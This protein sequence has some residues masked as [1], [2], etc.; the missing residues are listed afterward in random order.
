MQ[1]CN[2]DGIP[3]MARGLQICHCEEAIGRRGNLGKALPDPYRPP[4]KRCWPP[5]LSLRGGRRPTWQSRSSRSDRRKAIG[6]IATASPRF[7][8]RFAP[9]N[10]KPESFSLSTFH[11]RFSIP[12]MP[13]PYK[14]HTLKFSAQNAPKL[15]IKISRRRPGG[16]FWNLQISLRAYK[17]EWPAGWRSCCSCNNGNAADCLQH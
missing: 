11:F 12:R 13:L 14:R 1:V 9:R 5:Y 17:A 2:K 3:S 10:D 7:P 8:R 6:E 4:L 15:C 16:I